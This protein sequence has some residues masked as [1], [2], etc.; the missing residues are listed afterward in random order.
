MR[1]PTINRYVR[2]IGEELVL[3]AGPQ[4]FEY[5]FYVVQ[6][7]ALN[8][9]AAPG[10]YIY[11]N[12]GT[13]LAARNVSELAGVLAHEVGHVAKR[14][15]AQN[16]NRAQATRR[17]RRS[18][19]GVLVSLGIFMRRH[20]WAARP[21]IGTADSPVCR[22]PQQLRARRRDGGRRLRRR[23]C[24]RGRATIPNGLVVSFFEHARGPAGRRPRAPNFLSSHPGDPGPL[25]RRPGDGDRQ[26]LPAHLEPRV[27]PIGGKLE[28][29]QTADPAPHR[30]RA[31]LA[32]PP[33]ASHARPAPQSARTLGALRA[34]GLSLARPCVEELREN[35]LAAASAP[36]RAPLRGR[37]RLRRQRRSRRSRTRCSAAT[38]LIFLGERGQAK[39]RMIRS[40][41]RTCSTSGC[42]RWRAARST[43][44]RCAPISAHGPDACVAEQGDDT[45][46]SCLGPPR[47][48][49]RR[50]ARHPRRLRR[51][52]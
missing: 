16:Y 33:E 20:T 31:A 41:D 14:H 5:T 21:I 11:V 25:S 18:L 17:S 24:C 46:R 8:A 7:E 35:L 2:E 40:L 38:T 43:T 51:R 22:L 52:T 30:W 19:L 3:A 37:D 10:G 15:I 49:L 13:I 27:S 48:A 1:D 45:A 44:I 39:T 9:F 32:G 50:E 4:P 47:R 6:D 29:I 42:P 12:I 23:A 28:I 26:A 34:S 36:G